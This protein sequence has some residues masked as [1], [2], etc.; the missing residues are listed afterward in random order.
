MNATWTGCESCLPITLQVRGHDHVIYLQG[1]MVNP[2]NNRF[3]LVMGLCTNQSLEDFL[4]ANR[5]YMR[6]EEDDK[7]KLQ[8]GAQVR[9]KS[10][11]LT[12]Q[13]KSDIKSSVLLFKN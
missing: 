3:H 11:P 4:D 6:D 7:K 9:E 8:W 5:E 13:C 10:S 1:I 12:L 2:E